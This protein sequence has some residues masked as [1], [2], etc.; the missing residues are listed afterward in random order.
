MSISYINTNCTNRFNWILEL[1]LGTVDR[2][3][4]VRIIRFPTTECILIDTAQPGT[5]VIIASIGK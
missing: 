4:K 3:K 1:Q 2:V 5:T